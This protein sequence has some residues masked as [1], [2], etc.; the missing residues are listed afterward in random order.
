MS[1]EQVE[2]MK[3]LLAAQA[4]SMQQKSEPMLNFNATKGDELLKGIKDK[5]W[6]QGY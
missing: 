1:A 6:R 5:F 2:Y 4:E 3:Q